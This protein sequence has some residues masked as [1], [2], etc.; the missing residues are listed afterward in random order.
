MNLL[1]Q[2]VN[3]KFVKSDEIQNTSRKTHVWS[4]V[5]RFPSILNADGVQQS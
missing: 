2:N 3:I 5:I 1:K 4:R